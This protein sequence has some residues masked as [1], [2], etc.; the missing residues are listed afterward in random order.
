MPDTAPGALV[1]TQWLADRL[2][3]PSVHPV[4]VV[5][6]MPGLDRDLRAEHAARHIP[7]AVLFDVDDIADQDTDLPHMMPAP[8]L[9]GDKLGQLGIGNEDF[10]VCYDV[11][12]LLSAPRAWW[13]LRAFGHERVAVLDGGLPKWLAEGRPVDSTVAEPTAKPFAANLRPDLVRG[14]D[15]VA[16]GPPTLG[17]LVDV[18]AADRFAGEAPEVWPGRRWGHIPGSRNLPFGELID[19]ATGTLLPEDVLAERIAAAG[20]DPAHPVTAMCGSGVTACILALAMHR[21]GHDSVAVYDGS[22][23]DW[24]RDANLPLATGAAVPTS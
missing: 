21:L 10:V 1:S 20:I 23:A 5:F 7:G 24:G 15:Q 4:D 9:F 8:D 16:A 17:Q 12:G 22:W 6:W 2:G 3:D 18:R 13:M 11:F 19:P 14:R